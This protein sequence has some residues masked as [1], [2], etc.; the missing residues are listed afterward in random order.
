[1]L[2]STILASNSAKGREVIRKILRLLGEERMNVR[3]LSFQ[4]KVGDVMSYTVEKYVEISDDPLK[5]VK[6]LVEDAC[7]GDSC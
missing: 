1:M 3:S 2:M 7:E 5:D 6:A 4:W